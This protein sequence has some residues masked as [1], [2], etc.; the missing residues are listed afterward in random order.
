[1]KKLIKLLKFILGLVAMALILLTFFTLRSCWRGIPSPINVQAYFQKE[2]DLTPSQIRAVE[3]IGEWEFLCITDEE[4]VDT[5]ITHW[6]TP[7]DRLVRIYQGSLRLGIDFQDCQE[8]WAT[9]KGDTAILRLPPIK[10]LDRNFIDEARAR[11]FYEHGE[12][13]AQAKEDLYRR[14]QRRMIDRCLTP[15][16]IQRAEEN[17]RTQVEALFRTLGYKFVRVEISPAS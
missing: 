15:E 2:I 1:M 10:L 7:D 17:A 16:N 11:S 3:Q 14:A 6:F 9:S 13:D 12:W 5:A 4:M 8:H